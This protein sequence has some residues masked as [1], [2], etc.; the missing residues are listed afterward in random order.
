MAQLEDYLDITQDAI[1]LKGHRIGLEQIV[2]AYRNG[3]TA[4]DI[5]HDFPGLPL[6]SIYAALTYY[7]RNQAQIDGY[8]AERE[9]ES[10]AAYQAWVN[11]SPATVQRLRSLRQRPTPF[12]TT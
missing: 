11:S 6:E 9:A 12:E 8:I 3:A 5:A 7:L 10:E 4:E 2:R 1:T